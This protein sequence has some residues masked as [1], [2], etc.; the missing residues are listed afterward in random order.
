MPASLRLAHITGLIDILNGKGQISLHS[1]THSLFA[2]G[3]VAA[4]ATTSAG[5]APFIV[6]VIVAAVLALGLPMAA[7]PLVAA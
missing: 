1:G 4:T 5:W 2:S 7:G 6:A 3:G